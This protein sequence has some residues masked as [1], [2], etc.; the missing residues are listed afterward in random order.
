MRTNSY[1]FVRSCIGPSLMCVVRSMTCIFGLQKHVLQVTVTQVQ[2]RK[3]LHIF[4]GHTSACV[5]LMQKALSS[6]L[7]QTK[8]FQ[9]F[10]GFFSSFIGIPTSHFQKAADHDRSMRHHVGGS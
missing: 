3:L 5:I 6:P 8:S 2:V 9:L 7:Q 4:V 1:D 10:L